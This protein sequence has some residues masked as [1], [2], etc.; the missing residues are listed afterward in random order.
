[1][2]GF[3]GVFHISFRSLTSIDYQLHIYN[4]EIW[5]QAF[6]DSLNGT[7]GI[8]NR[9]E[10]LA[11]L[12]KLTNSKASDNENWKQDGNAYYWDTLTFLSKKTGVCSDFAALMAAYARSIGIPARVLDGF[13]TH[14]G[15][16]YGG[17]SW[18]EGWTGL[19]TINND[20]LCEGSWWQSYCRTSSYFPHDISGDFNKEQPLMMGRLMKPAPDKFA[21]TIHGETPSYYIYDDKT[22]DCA[23][24]FTLISESEENENLK[25]T[26]K[27]TAH[28]TNTLR[29]AESGHLTLVCSYTNFFEF[30]SLSQ[31][32]P[33]ISPDDTDTFWFP[34]PP[35]RGGLPWFCYLTVVY[36]YPYDAR[37]YYTV[38]TFNFLING[39]GAQTK[40]ENLGGNPFNDNFFEVQPFIEIDGQTIILNS[41][42]SS[43]QDI[44]NNTLSITDEYCG[45]ENYSFM[46]IQEKTIEN[47]SGY[48]KDSYNLESRYNDSQIFTV[49]IPYY[50]EGDAAYVPGY[51]IIRYNTE[52]NISADYLILYNF[53]SGT[54]GNVTVLTFSRS[55]VIKNI[56]YYRYPD[57][58]VVARVITSW[59]Y[60][61]NPLGSIQTNTYM[62]VVH[63]NGQ[64]FYEIYENATQ[65]I[66]D[67]DDSLLNLNISTPIDIR[68]GDTL[69]V[70]LSVFNNGNQNE[71]TTITL[72]VTRVI[73]LLPPSI[74]SIYE[75]ETTITIAPQS[76]VTL[77]FS[78]TTSGNN[79]PWR[80]FAQATT[81][82]NISGVSTSSME[83]CFAV[84][85][86]TPDGI[87]QN[88]NFSFNVTITNTWN[89]IVHNVVAELNLFHCFLIVTAPAQTIFDLQPF[90][91][92]TLHWILSAN[93]LDT[94]PIEIQIGSE[95]G[96][97]CEETTMLRTLSPPYLTLDYPPIVFDQ[98]TPFNVTITVNNSGDHVS[99]NTS[100]TLILPENITVNNATKYLGSIPPHEHVSVSWELS[101]NIN[102]SFVFLLN[103][104]SDEEQ[105]VEYIKAVLNSPPMTPAE[106]YGPTEGI[107][108]E[109]YA[110]VTNATDPNRE[111]VFYK[112]DWGDGNTSGWLGPY[113]SGE[114]TGANHT[115]F[116]VGGYQVK[117]KAKDIHGDESNWSE[118]LNVQIIGNVHINDLQSK[119]N[120]MSLPFNQSVDKMN[121]IIKYNG[122]NYSWQEAVNQSIVLGFIYAWNRTNQNY[123][124]TDTLVPGE[125]YWVYAYHDCELWASGVSGLVTDNYITDLL[126]KWNIMGVPD[127]ESVEKQNLTILYNGTVYT[128]QEAVTNNIILGFI[129]Q[130][131]E[132]GQTY[133][134]TDVL[135]PGKSY[136]MYAY[137]NC[138]L[139]RPTI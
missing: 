46:F 38:N 123:L 100:I 62:T 87:D 41:S 98:N 11:K 135:Q 108:R 37:Y 110:Y 137:Y 133:Q 103:V 118:P 76:S 61:I 57:G 64:E 125:G 50:Q 81:D 30:K 36:T 124:L 127:G 25:V 117:V 121:L 52:L 69:P 88:T 51:G 29:G 105:K 80:L 34:L 86:N 120:F 104:T 33:V 45:N 102:R 32:I 136:W 13:Y 23:L 3:F 65:R 60:E 59:D 119:W 9:D 68:T 14:W 74:T 27:N 122:S 113:P 131:G 8:I 39:V 53:T 31:Y 97:S 58:T 90:E 129:Y 72:N 16:D 107:I 47:T 95:N 96:G 24:D 17:H 63:G 112:F 67:K 79:T 130:W 126:S 106:P 132:T 128:W 75:N 73:P 19:N 85:F 55:T 84:E 42:S 48:L 101:P 115:W 82:K 44:S 92:K 54:N 5:Y 49:K 111:P 22:L 114:N 94:L 40:G 1:M 139:L 93:A 91:S 20:I 18:T 56:S 28:I 109:E 138:T 116:S 12:I 35:Y 21:Q 71:T 70:N 2:H 26:I 43:H 99:H 4:E 6:L 134:L 7:N 15:E 89:A 10:A 83:H 66:Y 77:N 78:I